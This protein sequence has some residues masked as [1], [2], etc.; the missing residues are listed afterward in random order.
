[1]TKFKSLFPLH[2]SRKSPGDPGA[3]LCSGER[4][5]SL[6]PG[7][8]RLRFGGAFSFTVFASPGCLLP[9]FVFNAVL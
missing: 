7:D 8:L 6:F 1:V 5:R 3:F 2:L 4:A 9:G